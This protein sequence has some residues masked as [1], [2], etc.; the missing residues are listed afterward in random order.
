LPAIRGSY[1]GLGFH[2]PYGFCE[3]RH[4]LERITDD[5]IV[6]HLEDRRI[7]ILVDGHDGAGG[8]HSCEVLDGA[9]DAHG[10]VELGRDNLAGLSDLLAVGPPAGIHD[11]SGC[12]NGR[13]AKCCGKIFDESEMLGFLPRP[14]ETTTG[15]SLTSSLVSPLASIETTRAL[16]SAEMACSLTSTLLSPSKISKTLR[17]VVQQK[18]GAALVNCAMA[19]PASQER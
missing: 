9:G 3:R 4:D 5:A 14:P 6:G 18:A 2:S 7:R 16:A 17:R 8:A 11:G 13:I 12:A 15:A 1:L 19:L 10:H